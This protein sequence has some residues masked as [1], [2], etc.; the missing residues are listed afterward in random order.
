MK[1]HATDWN[2]LFYRNLNALTDSTFPK[3]CPS[4]STVYETQADFMEATSPVRDT[5]LQQGSGLI[6][7][8]PEDDGTVSV[9]RNCACGSTLMA[10]FRSRRDNSAQG[11]ERRRRFDDLLT[12]LMHKGMTHQTARA[13]LLRVLGGQPSSLIAEILDHDTRTLEASLDVEPGAATQA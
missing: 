11:R 12:M 1:A 5:S 6:A 10:D 9:F 4:C 7:L 2:S 8:D 3:R 13:E